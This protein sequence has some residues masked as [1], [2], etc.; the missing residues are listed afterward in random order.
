MV[1]AVMAGDSADVRHGNGLG[2][3]WYSQKTST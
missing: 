2:S 1:K 3:W